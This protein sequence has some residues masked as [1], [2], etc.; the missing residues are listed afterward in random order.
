MTHEELCAHFGY[1]GVGVSH[2]GLASAEK[3]G[4]M[5]HIHPDGTPAYEGCFNF[6]GDF[7]EGLARARKGAWW[8]HI[9]RDGTPS[10]KE[11]FGWIPVILGDFKEGMAVVVNLGDEKHTIHS[12]FHIRSNGKPAYEER[13]DFVGPFFEGLAMA[14]KDGLD[15]HIRSNGKPA[16]KERSFVDLSQF[17]GGSAWVQKG[18][19]RYLIYPDGTPVSGERRKGHMKDV[20][21]V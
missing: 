1:E 8:F 3:D 10:Y 9:R 7:H 15:F 12:Q 5:F 2:E 13:Y 4:Q 19:E 21:Y 14:M 16:Y 17:R 18:D 11:R 6:V 20:E